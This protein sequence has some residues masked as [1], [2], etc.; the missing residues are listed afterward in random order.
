M[1]AHYVLEDG[2]ALPALVAGHP[3]LEFCNTLSGWDASPGSDYLTSY[4]HLA[5][6]A[7]HVRLLPC[8]HVDRSRA[9]AQRQPR[10]AA[11]VL[12]RARRLRADLY[13][14]LTDQPDGLAFERLSGAV[15]TMTAK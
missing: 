1:P 15:D 6:W 4:D 8:D 5:V 11:A 2:L 14:V 9:A 12:E 7:R 13:H 10:D 3:A